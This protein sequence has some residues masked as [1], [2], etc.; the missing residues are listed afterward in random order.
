MPAETTLQVLARGLEFHKA[1]KRGDAEAAYRQVL[2][3]DPNNSDALNLLGTLNIQ[4]GQLEMA[5]QLIRRAIALRPKAAQYYNNLGV[6]L[7]HL[8]DANAAA[9]AYQTSITLEP[10]N[11]DAYNN[12][13]NILLKHNRL[14]EAVTCYENAVRL[15]PNSADAHY[16]LAN[17]LKAQDRFDAAIAE[18]Q[19]ALRIRPNYAD[20]LNNLGNTYKAQ[21]RH[22]E[23]IAQYQAA[24]RV[25]PNDAELY[26]NLGE[27]LRVAGQTEKAVVALET[28]LRL[29]PNLAE[30]HCNLGNALYELGRY[31]EA[32]RCYQTTLT[33]KPNLTLAHCD[34]AFALM[35]LGEFQE[36][37]PHYEW[38]RRAS[39]ELKQPILEPKQP[40]WDGREL[41]RRKLLLH[42]EQGYGDTIQFIR[43]L[44]IVA[45]RGGR[46]A[47][48]CQRELLPLLRR[49][50]G[51]EIWTALEPLPDCD[52]QCPL[53]SLPGLFKTNLSNIPAN[54]PYL[55]A[56]PARTESWKSRLP[57]DRL[58]VGLAWAGT[59]GH[60]NDHNRSIKLQQLAG[61][62]RIPD[63]W[64]TSL[65]KGPAA[66]QTKTAPMEI[67]DWS[68]EFNDFA[69]TAALMHNLDLVITVD[70]SIAHL[71]GAMGKPVWTMLPFS[72]D[73]R[74]MIKRSDSPWYPTMRL[75]RQPEPGNWSAVVEQ[76][77]LALRSWK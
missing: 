31:A 26:S 64:F 11:A 44:P 54:V 65:Q 28:A 23:A 63:V 52:V 25:R 22:D 38:R 67:A 5:V 59:P 35:I 61:L 33:L 15:Q 34:Y 32:K 20:A 58:K 68:G 10:K 12:L 7:D 69:D 2:A 66:A 17:A 48:A 9:Q 36:G 49:M 74:W 60:R 47:V 72:P 43:Y 42:T 77:A 51:A 55:S 45:Q 62:A 21:K 29:R 75:F 27:V 71:A 53:L 70:T 18:Y 1:G 19:M 46:I 56:D 57:A 8:G 39:I 6:A 50:P 16:H 4:A 76:V 37:W 73:W 40:M 14:E 13:G 30:A 24:L 41:G 3:V